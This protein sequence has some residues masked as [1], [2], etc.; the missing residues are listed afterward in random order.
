MDAD[1][2][3]RVCMALVKSGHTEICSDLRKMFTTEVPFSVVCATR[4]LKDHVDLTSHGFEPDERM[5]QKYIDDR[6][7][8]CNYRPGRLSIHYPDRHGGG[9]CTYII[10]ELAEK[11]G[12]LYDPRSYAAYH[13]GT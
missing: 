9:I 3:L 8:L 10:G 1:T 13:K 12:A 2:Q 4:E 11:Y 5:I 6:Y 7:S